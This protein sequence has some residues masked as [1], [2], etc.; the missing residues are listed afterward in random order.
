MP[1]P[2]MLLMRCG[3]WGGHTVDTVPCDRVPEAFRLHQCMSA[4]NPDLAP[5]PLYIE[6]PGH[7]D[8]PRLLQAVWGQYEVPSSTGGAMNP[9]YHGGYTPSPIMIP[10][11][12]RAAYLSVRELRGWGVEGSDL[13]W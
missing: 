10:R 4:K 8:M 3:F 12:L 5:G 13:L 6:R 11:M 7:I 9:G 2:L 1:T